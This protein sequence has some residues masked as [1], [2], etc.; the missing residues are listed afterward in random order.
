MPGYKGFY[1]VSNQGRVRSEARIVKRS[2]GGTCSYPERI[3]RQMTHPKSGYLRVNLQRDSTRWT[4]EVHRLVLGAFVGPCPPG[5]QTLHWDDTPTN[6][7]LA[8]LRYGT[9]SDNMHD[10]V[11]NGRHNNANKTHCKRNHEFTASN[12][13]VIA[14]ARRCR[15]CLA[16]RRRSRTL[17]TVK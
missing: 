8:N 2:N 15:A 7:S 3:L 14:G 10:R 12:T 5:M 11:R 16:D 6:N 9:C 1:S 17:E 13:V 4:I